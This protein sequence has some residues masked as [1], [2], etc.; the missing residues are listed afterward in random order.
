MPLYQPLYMDMCV[1]EAN[2]ISCVP[3][4][5]IAKLANLFAMYLMRFIKKNSNIHKNQQPFFS[6]LPKK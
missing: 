2:V 3:R 1:I 6:K 5:R 4:P